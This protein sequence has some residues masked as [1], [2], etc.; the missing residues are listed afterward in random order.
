MLVRHVPE[1]VLGQMLEPLL[2]HVLDYVTGRLPRHEPNH[3]LRHMLKHVPQNGLLKPL[4]KIRYIRIVSY[5]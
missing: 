1:D 4:S 3:L 2:R 5:L